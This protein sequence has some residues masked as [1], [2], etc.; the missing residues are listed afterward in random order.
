MPPRHSIIGIVE[1]KS[2]QKKTLAR[3]ESLPSLGSVVKE[4]LAV[5]RREYF[6][7]SDFEKVIRKDQALVARLLKVANSSFFAGGRSI[8][9]IHDAVVLIGMDNMKNMVYAVSSSGLLRREMDCYDYPGRGFWTH[10]MAVAIT[11]R[12]LAEAMKQPPLLGEEAFVA[13]LLH[14]IGKLVLDELFDPIPGRRP[15]CREEEEEVSGFEHPELA[16]HVLQRWK[17]PE[18]IIQAVRYHHDPWNRGKSHPAAVLV[19]LSDQLCNQWGLG[20]RNLEDLGREVDVQDYRKEMRSLGFER[21]SFLRLLWQL[22]QD[23]QDLD[24]LYAGGL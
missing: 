15:I 7:A 17:L 5:A 12:K 8:S 14:D 1:R 18:H 19:H 4:F 11:S 20:R 6:T 10:A 24:H 23:L 22:R 13:G 2:L 16:R 9:T 21:E 3:M